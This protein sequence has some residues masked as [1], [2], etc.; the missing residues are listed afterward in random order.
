MVGVSVHECIYFLGQS[1]FFHPADDVPQVP[2][3]C[4]FRNGD[5]VGSLSV[6]VDILQRPAQVEDRVTIGFATL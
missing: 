2:F 4:P 5:G 1:M 6:V 3:A